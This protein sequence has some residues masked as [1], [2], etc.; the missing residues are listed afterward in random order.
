MQKDMTAHLRADKSS[1]TKQNQTFQK[2][3]VQ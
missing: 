2:I 3:A 1:D